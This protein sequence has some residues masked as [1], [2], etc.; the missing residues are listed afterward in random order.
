MRHYVARQP[1]FDQNQ[2]V[3]AYELLYRS[4]LYNGYSNE[5]GGRATTEVI[6][7]S[8]LLIGLDTLT[9]GK[10]A[11]INF[12]GNLLEN[13]VATLLPAGLAVIEILEDSEPD[14]K[15]LEVCKKLK[16]MGYQLALD[17]FVYEQKFAPL[18][19]LADIIKVDFKVTGAAERKAVINRLG[20]N[21]KF[22]AEKVE[23]REEFT[24]AL[25]IGYSYFQGYFF[26]KPIIVSGKDVPGNKLI[27]LQLL[28]DLHSQEFDF[29]QIE[30][31]FKRD[32]SLSYQLL[33][34]INSA[35][36]SF[37]SEINSIKQA[38]V[39]LGQKEISKWLSLVALKGIGEDKPDEL[40][41]TSIC[42][43]IFCELI[44]PKVGLSHSRS[45]LFLL[46]MFSLIDA[47]LDQPLS[48][49]L[50]GLPISMEIKKALLGEQSLFKDVYNLVLFYERGDWENFHEISVKLGLDEA[51]VIRFYIDSLEIVNQI[52]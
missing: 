52:F 42:R 3:F 40:F 27:Y 31:L 34:Y 20:K 37:R 1:I 15:V 24:Q 35:S 49:I 36:F 16:K 22:L 29:E 43:A 8:L 45:D 18:I 7:N 9:R 10:K 2:E 5:D 23:T 51:E 4:A 46:G 26:S 48:G 28:Q 41:V 6:T 14:E 19:E 44:A 30:S 17:D 13:E 21:K 11:F 12:T 47:F 32:V 33:K 39:M 38:L 50:T 25:E